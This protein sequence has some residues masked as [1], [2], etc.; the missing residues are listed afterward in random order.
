MIDFIVA[1]L[2]LIGFG[3]LLLGTV[4][5]LAVC[6]EETETTPD[7][8]RE[9]LDA[10]ARISGMA[11]EAERTIHAIAHEEGGRPEDQ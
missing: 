6:L 11:F 7:P 10:A 4:V 9:S 1:L 5:A 8:Y 3:V 2:A